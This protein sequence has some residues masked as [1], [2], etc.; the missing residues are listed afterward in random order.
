VVDV[1]EVL[2]VAVDAVWVV[3]MNVVVLVATVDIAERN[4]IQ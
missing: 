2:V 1:V 3:V 4:D